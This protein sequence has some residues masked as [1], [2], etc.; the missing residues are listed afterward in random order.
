MRALMSNLEAAA[1]HRFSALRQQGISPAP[2]Q[3]DSGE[4]RRFEKKTASIL[5]GFLTLL[6]CELLGELLRSALHLPIPGPVI[7]MLLLATGLALRGGKER[8]LEAPAA[9]SLDR[10]AAGLLRHMGLLFVPAGVGIVA[11]IG[12]L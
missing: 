5:V 9:S 7:G 6:V 11:E 12:V 1:W 8:E 10:V 4:D 2:Q 3:C